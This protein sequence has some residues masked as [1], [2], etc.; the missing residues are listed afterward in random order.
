MRFLTKR[1]HKVVAIVEIIAYQQHL[2]KL[3]WDPS[4][5]CN[6]FKKDPGFESHVMHLGRVVSS[7]LVFIKLTI[8]Q[9]QEDLYIQIV[10]Q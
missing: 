6:N 2:R 4:V 9:S 1:V 7:V 3:T 8:I 5:T 10:K